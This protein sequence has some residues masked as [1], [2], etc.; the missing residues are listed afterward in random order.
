[1]KAKF[2]KLGITVALV[3]AL[4]FSL[5]LTSSAA[6]KVEVVNDG[7]Q[8]IVRI[9]GE[10]VNCDQQ[11]YIANNCTMVPVSIIAKQLGATVDWNPA[12]MTVTIKGEK[13]V[14]LTIGS[15]TAIKDGSPITLQAP[16]NATGGRTMVPLR[17]VSEALG[18]EVSYTPPPVEMVQPTSSGGLLPNEDK[19][20]KELTQEDIARLQ[21]YP[22]KDEVTYG[23]H[24]EVFINPQYAET[25]R[26]P[27]LFLQALK[28]MQDYN[29]TVDYE[30]FANQTYTE[31]FKRKFFSFGEKNE[32]NESVINDYINDSIKNKIKIR[33]YL[34]SSNYVMYHATPKYIGVR[35]KYIFYQDSGT[36]IVEEGST[37]KKWYWQDLE[38]RF[39]VLAVPAKG[40][41]TGVCYCD[42]QKL[43][44]PQPYFN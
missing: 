39:T 28:I 13:V 32:S 40:N 33:A 19:I 9:N 42:V 11:P 1:M 25:K 6:Q 4:M 15:A 10:Q 23:K 27:P 14:I 5:T 17:F 8:L 29:W 35:T 7:K 36:R 38:L 18:A 43:S 2:S 3:F 24:F 20:Q 41:T 21:N 37:L 12:T 26:I 22:G 34:L 44:T 31:D 16:A 30:K